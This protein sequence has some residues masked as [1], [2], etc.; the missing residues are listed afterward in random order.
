[1][2]RYIISTL[3][4]VDTDALDLENLDIN[5]GKKS[6][7]E[8]RDVAVKVKTFQSHMPPGVDIVRT[9]VGKLIMTI[10]VDV[11][12]S[13]VTVLMTDIDIYLKISLH[14][15]ENSSG[16]K[17]KKASA[18]RKS[19]DKL[20]ASPHD[21]LPSVADLAQSFLNTEDAQEKAELEAALLSQSTVSSEDGDDESV[22]AVGTGAGLSLP[23]FM[24]DFLKG[25]VDKLES[26]FRGINVHLDVEI[27]SEQK[28]GKPEVI[29]LK[30]G[31]EDVDIEGVTYR[32]DEADEKT[33][34]AALPLKNGKRLVSL[35]NLR[36]MLVSDA[37]IFA[38]MA[39]SSAMSS[40]NMTSED[41]QSLVDPTKSQPVP[42]ASSETPSEI[43]QSSN[44][45][46][47]DET[48]S[49]HSSCPPSPSA[50]FHSL[51]SVG[52]SEIAQED[53]AHSVASSG[54]FD[55][56]PEEDFDDSMPTFEDELPLTTSTARLLD[57]SV[58]LDQV[59]GS[60]EMHEVSD[61]S[62]AEFPFGT[63]SRSR[64]SARKSKESTPRAS[65]YLSTKLESPKSA[66][67][68]EDSSR[69][70][71]LPT[72]SKLGQIE[73]QQLMLAPKRSAS[74]V[75]T[76][77]SIRG[78]VTRSQVEG[79][80][81]PS[82]SGSSVS[83]DENL[84]ESKLFSPEEAQS[85]YQ[86]ALSD[87]FHARVPGGWDTSSIPLGTSITDAR[88][89]QPSHN[90]EADLAAS[91]H[92]PDEA[93]HDVDT[94]DGAD[95]ED[96]DSSNP[97]TP[98]AR[99]VNMLHTTT[100]NMSSPSTSSAG[101]DNRL[102]KQLF[103]LD[104]LGIYLPPTADKQSKPSDTFKEDVRA[105][106]AQSSVQAVPGAFSTPS[107]AK[108]KAKDRHPSPGSAPPT[109]VPKV[110]D[111]KQQIEVAVGQ[112]YANFDVSVARLLYSVFQSV[113]S[114]IPEAPREPSNN[115]K[116]EDNDFALS[117][118][119]SMERFSLKF[120]ERLP[121][122]RLS[123]VSAN[124]SEWMKP[125]SSDVLLRTT[126]KGLHAS[127]DA[128]GKSI[129]AS[130]SLKKFV[131]GYAEENILSFDGEIQMRESV[132]DLAAAA[133]VDVSIGMV[134]NGPKSHYNVS[135]LPLRVSINLQKLDE[136]FSWFG[137]LSSVLNMTNSMA[138][139]ATMTTASP[140]KSKPKGVRFDDPKRD[141]YNP[142]DVPGV[143]QT[144]IDLRIGGFMLDLIG[145]ECSVG[146]DTSAVKIVGRDEI[147]GVGID[148]IS[149]SGPHLGIPNSRPAIEAKIRGTRVDFLQK[150]MDDDL[151][152]L[153]ALITPSKSK[154]DRDD[155]ILLDTLLKQRR[156]GSVLRLT[157]DSFKLR[158][159]QLDEL[160]YLP[161]LGEELAKLST[162][163]KYLP[164]DD[165][166]GL[167]SLVLI[168]EARQTVDFGGA[169]GVLEAKLNEVRLAHI[170]MPALVALSVGTSNIHRNS[171]EEIIVPA[172]NYGEQ[173]ED[174]QTPMIMARMIGDEMEPIVKV[175]LW[176]VRCEYR[177]PTLMAILGTDDSAST[178]DITIT[179]AT[180]VATLLDR[181][182]LPLP[183][184]K[185]S[186][187]SKGQEPRPMTV[188][189]AI[190][191]CVLGLNP[192][193]MP[194]K[195]LVVMTEAHVSAVLPVNNN[196]SAKIEMSKLTV[197]VVNDVASL[198]L[199]A[200]PGDRKRRYSFDGGSTQIRTLDAQG[201]V[202]VSNLNDI[203]ATINVLAGDT[204]DARIV[205]VELRNELLILE[206]CADST[207]TLITALGA[208]VPPPPPS[209]VKKYKTDRSIHDNPMPIE[210]LM[211]S[212]TGD[213]IDCPDGEF[214]FDE[215]FASHVDAADLVDDST[216]LSFDE[217]YF[218]K[219]KEIEGTP[220]P[221]Q[222]S[223]HG[224]L[225]F[226]Q[227]DSGEDTD[228]HV[229]VESFESKA[230]VHI[231]DDLDIKE[232]YFGTGSV[233]EGTAHRWNSAKN[234]YDKSDSAL[235]RESPLK[236][237]IRDVNIIW[238]V[239]DGYDW[240]STRDAI[241]KAAQDVESKALAKRAKREGQAEEDIDF[242]EEEGEI[243][244]FL[245]NS[246]YIGVGAAKDPRDLA[247][248]I[249]RDLMFQDKFTETESVA[250]TSATGRTVTQRPLSTH[251]KSKRLRL[252]R[253]KQHKLAF[254]LKG[255][256]VD[257]VAFPPDSGETLSTLD[258]RVRDLEI[259]D[260]MGTSTWRK[261]ACYCDDH[262]KRETGSSMIHIELLNV[263]PRRDLAATEF[264]LKAWV[265]PLRLHVDHDALDFITRFFSF[266]DDSLPASPAGEPPFIQRA[267][268]FDIAVKLDFKPKRVDYGGIRSGKTTEFMNFIILDGSDMV[269][270]HTILYGVSGFDR[271]GEMLNDIW[272]PEV[273]NNQLPGVLAGLAP[274]RSLANIGYGM[275]QLIQVPIQEYRKD[276]RIVR[277][278][279]KGVQKFAKTGGIEIFKLGAKLAVGTQ[280]ILEGVEGLVGAAPKTERHISSDWEGDSEDDHEPRQISAYA[281]QP[282]NVAAGLKAAYKDLERDL[283]T[284]RGA[285]I[286]IPGEVRDSGSAKG[287][288]GVIGRRAPTI[289]LR[290][291]LGASK[292]V[293]KTLMG[294]NNWAD[295]ENL[296]RINDKYK[297][298]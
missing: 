6:S 211:A 233:V 33:K 281:N 267:E 90:A 57:D 128:V 190:S 65:M 175:K 63:E 218:S 243:G 239:F 52:G 168:K 258:V 111:S 7:L 256:N 207:A 10:P 287:A 172:I 217:E 30:I 147:I 39:R 161:A 152:R 112:L 235:V 189:I 53:M 263:K 70:E 137:G 88:S 148:E 125:P 252:E 238:K 55:D 62:D 167:L 230:H 194:S 135:T 274:V 234:K 201:F 262:G 244:D 196:A 264:V 114:L 23:T 97:Q 210:D 116:P 203:T 78:Q 141:L 35:R 245:F 130:L 96:P 113:S 246:I 191:D 198:E 50:S 1:M 247:N 3:D 293:A 133:G 228:D 164:E 37:A 12:N 86:S 193:E 92:V 226:N 266:K 22:S 74:P 174:E 100:S 184:A 187:N 120:L 56:A 15:L 5:W 208:L 132:K 91:I 107:L 227:S 290:P 242:A 85:M 178:E 145:K 139:N 221:K 155:D 270:K 49:A 119:L 150:P 47:L 66:L 149:I 36:G 248:I 94:K 26:R 205:D 257:L 261:F 61:D 237:R 109:P 156:Q 44:Q 188:D 104:Y 103:S 69:P 182:N 250:Q 95:E 236:V 51:H 77:G 251:G 286:A 285:I 272:M 31:V 283:L 18:G 216:S 138:S 127:Y 197:M 105:S 170:T 131:L 229:M 265:L 163:A 291:M 183:S 38:A 185:P 165:R 45:E 54:R 64:F 34:T 297:R 279:S 219:G 204:P 254:E 173:P 284:A 81:P 212:F 108:Q 67:S 99:S 223:E 129:N 40:P 13:P 277:A 225:L 73:D 121:G 288:A 241:T 269:L 253:S 24:T 14:S 106:M 87:E 102:G 2:A 25:I 169:V 179:V 160:K 21:I 79:F 136:T 98:I 213:A 27:P 59:S 162:V 186:K 46:Q 93:T 9:Q 222:E 154:Y 83:G 176:N 32:A 153:L 4:I 180:S 271:L 115:V 278:L 48:D 29:S 122:T 294:V 206:S 159:S 72:V 192:L 268:V 275:S 118:K 142:I 181:D 143:A 110:E 171:N 280:G 260:R 157:V 123:E 101:E 140:P 144:K 11:H 42:E 292:A 16:G 68:M 28:D 60:V 195:V 209:A 215:E 17:E 240:Q 289:V 200:R 126:F 295:P 298:N 220:K 259:I 199:T 76:A 231:Q 82:E 158:V 202:S 273:K 41:L 151:D 249:N 232:D 84:R 75:S 117:L 71:L 296:R 146:L 224:S 214:D 177:V 43:L 80:G 276:G 19:D 58:F 8:F 282:V 134:K 124:N 166:P 89:D 255:V 20:S